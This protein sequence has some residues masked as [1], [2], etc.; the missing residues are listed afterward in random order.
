MP[1]RIVSERQDVVRVGWLN[2]RRTL[3]VAPQS[4]SKK[5]FFRTFGLQEVNGDGLKIEL[6]GRSNAMTSVDNF[7]EAGVNC[8]ALTSSNQNRPRIRVKP[9]TAKYLPKIK[10]FELPLRPVWQT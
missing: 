1:L 5:D 8:L 3:I 2:A 6:R 10:I 4:D 9:M 7:M